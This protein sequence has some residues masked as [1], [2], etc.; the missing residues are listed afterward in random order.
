M[1][2]IENKTEGSGSLH[3]LVSRPYSDWFG[4]G[5]TKDDVMEV[6]KQH[7]EPLEVLLEDSGYMACVIYAD[8][9]VVV[10]YD[11]SEYCHTFEFRRDQAANI[12]GKVRRE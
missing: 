5:D 8:R 12:A 3:G 2:D 1:S 6:V 7:G 10:G 9:V 11:G 4:K